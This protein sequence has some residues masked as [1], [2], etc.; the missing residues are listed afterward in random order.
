M[1]KRFYVLIAV[2][3]VMAMLLSGCG[4]DEQVLPAKDIPPGTYEGTV[5][6]VKVIEGEEVDGEQHSLGIEVGDVEPFY[7]W[8]DEPYSEI[9]YKI[10]FDD[11]GEDWTIADYDPKTGALTYG[12][13]ESFQAELILTEKEGVPAFKGKFI[14]MMG[15]WGGSEHKIE[16]VKVSD[17]IPE[18]GR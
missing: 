10:G 8:I 3:V 14:S 5:T 18:E 1:K 7:L 13:G 12:A 4:D 15:V 9:S 11:T 6:V 2:Q 16:V 17:V